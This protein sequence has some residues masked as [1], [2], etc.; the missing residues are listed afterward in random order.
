MG[1]AA[2]LLDASVSTEASPQQSASQLSIRAEL[3][4][5]IDFQQLRWSLIAR[6]HSGEES[7]LSPGTKRPHVKTGYHYSPPLI[8]PLGV[9]FHW[10]DVCL[11]P[12]HL[13]SLSFLLLL[14]PA[15]ISPLHPAWLTLLNGSVFQG[16]ELVEEGATGHI[17]THCAQ[18]MTV[19]IFK[20]VKKHNQQAH[21]QQ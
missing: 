5:Q 18:Q 6:R 10:Q 13:S 21:T 19:L 11:S 17:H 7:L 16:L 8:S 12:P 4:V 3:F 1:G 15:A 9:D 2:D 14:L 20:L